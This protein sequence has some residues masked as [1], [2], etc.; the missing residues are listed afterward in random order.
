MCAGHSL[1]TSHAGAPETLTTTP[2]TEGKLRH[3]EGEQP[4]Q[5]G[6]ASRQQNQTLTQAVLWRPCPHKLDAAPLLRQ[7]FMSMGPC[8]SSQPPQT[9]KENTGTD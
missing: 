1:S 8:G 5:G 7:L 4:S 3:A 2:F 6:R 9:D